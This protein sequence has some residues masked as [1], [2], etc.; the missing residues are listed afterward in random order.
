MKCT[1]I[2]LNR[3]PLLRGQVKARLLVVTIVLG[4]MSVTAVLGDSVEIGFTFTGQILSFENP[5][6]GGPF[7]GISIGDSFIG[8]LAYDPNQSPVQ[9]LSFPD[10]TQAK[11]SIFTFSLMITTS[12][13]VKTFGA[14]PDEAGKMLVVDGLGGEE[15]FFANIV[16]Q[17][18]GGPNAGFFFIDTD[19]IAFNGAGLPTTLDLSLFE[20]ALV[21]VFSGVDPDSSYLGSITGMSIQPVPEPATL[22][23]LGI[24]LL[25]GAAFRKKFTG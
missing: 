24:G 17:N 11:Y 23:L 18:S 1:A 3:Y 20:T 9:F 8:S 12:S 25:G 22:T 15:D 14:T 2:P 16:A 19:G 6:G 21:R 10:F 4:L 7:G 13:G 5:N